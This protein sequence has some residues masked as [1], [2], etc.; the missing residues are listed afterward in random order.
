MKTFLKKEILAILGLLVVLA[1]SAL[2]QSTSSK[3]GPAV[4]PDAV[5]K[6]SGTPAPA[7]AK[8]A[9]SVGA[10]AMM[11]SAGDDG[12]F[13]VEEVDIDG[14]GN[15]EEADLLWDDADKV[16]FAYEGGTFTCANGGT[17]SGQLL[18]AVNAAGNSRNRPAG[19]GFWLADLDEGECDA[20]MDVLWGCRFDAYGDPTACGVATLDEENDELVIVTAK[21]S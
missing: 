5:Q 19:S 13:W 18:V 16:L 6:R 21:E 11:V 14:D 20:E 8:Q 1:A 12:S 3:T 2:A 9:K 7:D 10:S 4:D 17:G 15:V